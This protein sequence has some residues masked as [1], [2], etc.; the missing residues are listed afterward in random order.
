MRRIAKT[1]LFGW[2]MPV[3][4]LAG[5]L[6]PVG[7]KAQ[8]V[9]SNTVPA[10]T[11]SSQAV[12][13]ANG[14]SP[15]QPE[16]SELIKE[17]LGRLERLENKEAEQKQRTEAA[18][19]AH[20]EEV[21]K[22]LGRIGELEG[23]VGSLES[24]KVL[25]EIA[26]S[27]KDGPTTQELDQKLRVMARNEE[28]A[29][30]AAEAQAAA[31]AKETPRITAGANGFA[32]SSADTNYVLKLRGLV[33]V[34]SRSFF[35]DNQY[36]EGNDG[37]YLRRA[38]PIFE[39]TLF[40][41]FDFNLTPDFGG[42]NVQIFDAWM[43]YRYR[44]ELQL[45]AGKFK[46]PVG[47]EML[48]SV[49]MLPFNERSLVSNFVPARTLGLQIWG[50]IA[51]GAVSYAAGVFDGSGD[52]RV[53]SNSDIDDAKEFAGRLGFQPFKQSATT[54]LTG[55]RL[56]AGGS[57]TQVRSNTASLPNTTGGTLPGYVT[58]ALQQFFA[59][60]P[61]IGTVY[62]DGV[63][64]R[65]SPYAAYTLG[66]FGLL[67]EYIV[68]QQGVVNSVT[69][70]R[71]D[72]LDSA[73]QLSAQWVLTGEDA[74][75]TGIAPK[76]PFD[77]RA[78]KWGAWQLVARFAQADLDSDAFPV[79]SDP[80]LSAHSAMSWGIGLNWWLNRNV[81]VLTSYSRTWFGGGGEVN[82]V[83]IGT[84]V[85]PATVTHQDES[86]FMTRLQLAF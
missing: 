32:I 50:D 81:R 55:L 63:H 64:W 43:N 46:S 23:K 24:G 20:Q 84:H 29:A 27:P 66:P 11:P 85:P 3:M 26:V 34:D 62:A 6:S 68:A 72:L 79:F 70:A 19:K 60:N 35:D 12:P 9:S 10:A 47:F 31:R 2:N 74:S 54:M 39:G 44:P 28:L 52:A 53:A 76:S 86:V 73:W 69:G 40:R 13:A 48:Q 75:F 18:E 37:F 42:N 77:P 8:P 83:F 22:L 67:G 45:K 82:P 36:L 80:T 59:Y 5:L 16:Q 38:R 15:S 78:G 61:A 1:I 49:G 51:G 7:G 4:V 71:E 33:Q 30:E 56:G 58:S 21:Q 65:I 57:F 14:V 25:P 41:D 17:L